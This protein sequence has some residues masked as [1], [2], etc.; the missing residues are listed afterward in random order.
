MK[1]M[2]STRQGR[3]SG[4]WVIAILA[5]LIVGARFVDYSVANPYSFKGEVPPDQETYPP[6]ITIA[7][8]VNNTAY[9][10]TRLP[11]TFNVTAPQSRTASS[12]TVHNVAYEADWKNAAINLLQSSQEQP[13]FNL[14]LSNIPEGQH[15]II[16]KADG[17][18]IYVNE[19]ELSYKTFFISSTATIS[20]TIDCTAPTVSV[21]PLENVSSASPISLNVIVN[22]AYSKIAYSLNGQQ[23]VTVGGNSTIPYLP[24][25]QYNVTF[26]VWDIAGNIG[27]S[28]TANFTVAE[29]PQTTGLLD[30]SL[31]LPVATTLS[32]VVIIGIVLLFKRRMAHQGS[33]KT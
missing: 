24:A 23:N 10:T 4:I 33:I 13:S 6:V 26:Y 17:N 25:G 9:N 18:G 7:S 27:N 21:L 15:S 14:Q 29:I 3:I 30:D 22:E 2:K 31:L 20:F 28:E 1:S 8:P 32:L 11:L 16:I 12:T 5:L 19:E